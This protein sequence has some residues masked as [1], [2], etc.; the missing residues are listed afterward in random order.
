MPTR[1]S[2]RTVDAKAM[3][4]G[5]IPAAMAWLLHQPRP[6]KKLADLNLLMA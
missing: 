3:D 5:L 1:A 2:H 4:G 6:K